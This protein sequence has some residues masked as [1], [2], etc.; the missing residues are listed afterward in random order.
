MQ[1]KFIFVTG[2][3]MSGLGKGVSEA[4]ARLST[5]PMP[6]IMRKAKIAPAITDSSVRRVFIASAKTSAVGS[7]LTIPYSIAPRV[8]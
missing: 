2:G 1:T 8:S 6:S 3:V 5:K 4:S 7:R